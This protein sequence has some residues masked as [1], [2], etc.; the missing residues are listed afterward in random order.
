MALR[1]A[2]ENRTMQ[3]EF[4]CQSFDVNIHKKKSVESNK[5]FGVLTRKLNFACYICLPNKAYITYTFM[6]SL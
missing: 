5:I 2:K 4:A 6:A 3:A 1:K